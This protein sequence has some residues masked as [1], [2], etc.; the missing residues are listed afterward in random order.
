MLII[1][2]MMMMMM[3]MMMITIYESAVFMSFLIC[4]IF[5]LQLFYL[6]ILFYV[7]YLI[8]HYKMFMVLL[9]L[10]HGTYTLILLRN[11]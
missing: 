7:E 2:M 10:L 5:F 11:D 4:D 3:M 1:I 8:V 6:Y 9:S